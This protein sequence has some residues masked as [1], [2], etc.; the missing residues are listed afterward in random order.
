MELL[1]TKE[2]M[3]PFPLAPS[4]MF[5]LSFVQLKAAPVLPEKLTGVELSPSQ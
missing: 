1:T 4:P 5:V 2:A 3:F